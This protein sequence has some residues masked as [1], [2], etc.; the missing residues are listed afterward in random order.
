MINVD[1]LPLTFGKYR[2]QTP[3]QIADI[4][5]WYIEWMYENVKNA[6]CTESLYLRCKDII[7]NAD[8]YDY[9]CLDGME[10]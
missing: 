2:G 1:N 4:D 6:P 3:N 5:P 8:Y 9:I 10:W 7:E